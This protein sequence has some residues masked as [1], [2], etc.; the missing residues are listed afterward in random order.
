VLGRVFAGDPPPKFAL[1]REERMRDRAEAKGYVRW[2]EIDLTHANVRRCVRTA[3]SSRT[4]AFIST[5]L[6]AVLDS[7]A[8]SES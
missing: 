5:A 8:R 7:K 1:G 4:S 3:W 6:G 2:S